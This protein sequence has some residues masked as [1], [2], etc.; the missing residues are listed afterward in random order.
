MA[1]QWCYTR[2]DGAKL[3]HTLL[4]LSKFF[5]DIFT[6]SAKHFSEGKSYGA[7]VV[8]TLTVI[9]FAYTDL[10]LTITTE[11]RTRC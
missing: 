9:Q 10:N 6:E 2:F 7:G 5:T 11:R 4:C 1:I 8:V 3:L